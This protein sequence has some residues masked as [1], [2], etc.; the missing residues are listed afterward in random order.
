MCFFQVQKEAREWN[1]VRRRGKIV[2]WW[3]HQDQPE[4]RP[5][6]RPTDTKRRPKKRR[7][8]WKHTNFSQNEFEPTDRLAHND[9][10]YRSHG[11]DGPF[12]QSG[13]EGFTRIWT[14]RYNRTPRC[15]REL[16]PCR[17]IRGKIPLDHFFCLLLCAV[18]FQVTFVLCNLFPDKL[19]STLRNGRIAF[20]QEMHLRQSNS[21]LACLLLF[22]VTCLT[23]QWK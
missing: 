9:R 8:S 4:K 23:H 20:L 19:M 6:V 1:I 13:R 15:K 7:R 21:N 10:V 17:K 18:N 22:E 3:N 14:I 12:W 16:H 11:S 2:W 5:E